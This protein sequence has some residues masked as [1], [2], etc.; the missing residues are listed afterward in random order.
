MINVWSAAAILLLVVVIVQ[1][2][3]YRRLKQKLRQTAGIAARLERQLL[4]TR[5]QL[6][7]A[8]SRRKKLLAASTQSLI[9]VE[10]DYR[11]SSANKVAKRLFGPVNKT[12]TFTQWTRQHQLR[13][14]VDQVLR[15]E[16]TAP[17]YINKDEKALE[18][19]ARAIKTDLPDGQKVPVAVA[20]AIND[21]TE[22]Q[23]LTRARRDFVTNISHELRSPLASL[24]LLIDTL[25]SGG[26]EDPPLAADLLDKSIIQIETLNQLAQE[27]LDLSLIESGQ[28]PLRLSAL[29]LRTIAQAQI[30]RFW[31]QA[32]R[33]N[34]TLVN[35]IDEELRGLVDETMIG[36]V[37]ANLIHNG[38]KFTQAG[39]VTISARQVNGRMIPHEKS[40]EDWVLVSVADTGIGIPS[41]EISRIFERFYK[42]DRARTG[43]QAGT[44]LG[45]SIARHII[46][47]HSGRIWVES[48]GKTGSTFYFTLP[49]EE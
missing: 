25:R 8:Q 32:D 35:N 9:I 5:K 22:L 27:L 33:K 29:P 20:L 23:R 45:L 18:V 6:A 10:N 44:G 14:L 24:Q 28:M 37:F 46:E 4:I 3:F 49:P 7:E 2:V 34:L 1:V 16:K 38:I 12:V 48:D 21:V 31:P 47:G 40:H 11:V 15:G 36:R 26:L 17:I 13:E 41:D 43:K 30:E 19:H 42:V 39:S